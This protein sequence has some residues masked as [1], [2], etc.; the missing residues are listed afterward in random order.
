MNLL[1]LLKFKYKIYGKYNSLFTHKT[2][3][4]FKITIA[5]NRNII[6]NKLSKLKNVTIQ[7]NGNYNEITFESC[8]SIRDLKI[9]INGSN[10]RV[11]IGQ[12]VGYGGGQ[13]VC[14][15]DRRSIIIHKG[16]MIADNV[17][18]WSS[19]GHKIYDSTNQLINK[20]ADIVIKEDVWIGNNATI[21]KGCILEKGTI[22]GLGSIVTK[23][24]EPNCLYAGVPAKKIKSDVKWVI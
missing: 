14:E 4:E 7:I 16:T 3:S 23:N 8:R 19:D 12:N 20:P 17:D 18:I 5:G 24:T 13:I 21:L 10:C 6:T 2:S 15:G 1:G 9:I 22:I 11:F